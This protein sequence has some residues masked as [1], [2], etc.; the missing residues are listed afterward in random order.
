MIDLSISTF[1]ITLINVGILFGVLRGVLF[2][3]VTKFI[4]DRSNKVRQTIE[5]AEKDKQEAKA[6]LVQ[7]E[8]RLKNIQTEAE[9]IIRSAQEKAQ[10]E[11]D[12]I[13]AEG[14]TSANTLI[15]NAQKQI[16]AEQ[17]AALA[18]FQAEAGR[19]VIGAASR[20]IQRDLTQE[21]NRRFANLLLQEIGNQ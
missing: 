2:K 15:A 16:E 20:L 4:E 12:Q 7:Y 1:L 21:D 14:K 3:R 11:A 18:L 19:L 9:R 10:R 13:I 5:E 6:L 17:Q 8:A